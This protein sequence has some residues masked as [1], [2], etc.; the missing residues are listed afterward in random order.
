MR[1][2]A[3]GSN[4]LLARLRERTPSARRVG[5]GKV[6]AHR[7]CWHKRGLVDG[8]GKC[9]ALWTGDAADS[10]WGAV[11]ELSGVDRPTLD[12]VEGLGQGYRDTQVHVETTR[13]VLTAFAYVATPDAVDDT[14][15]PFGWYRDLVVAGA[16]ESGLPNRYVT[17]LASVAAI[18]DPDQARE[19]RHRRLLGV[20]AHRTER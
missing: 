11:F 19:N 16:R 9:D 2:F 7:L 10:V 13:G 17:A 6:S 12:A 5:R 18:A 14:L 4:L 20:A 8:S 15:A 3:Y 1:Y